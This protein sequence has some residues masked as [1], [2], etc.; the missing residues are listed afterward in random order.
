[1]VGSHSGRHGSLPAALPVSA[2]ARTGRW[3]DDAKTDAPDLA[4]EPGVRNNDHAEASFGMAQRHHAIK[5]R[6][7]L[8]LIAP[9]I[10]HH[11]SN[12]AFM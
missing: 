8:A 1:V 3:R 11:S 6:V 7:S 10:T 4:L 9:A 5:R 12:L 2:F